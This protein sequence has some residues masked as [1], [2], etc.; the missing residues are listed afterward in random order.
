MK[1]QRWLWGVL[2]VLSSSAVISGIVA[3]VSA[4]IRMSVYFVAAW[5][6]YVLTYAWMKADART[7]GS[8]PPPGAIPLI[9]VLLPIAVSYYLLGTRQRWH[10]VLALCWLTGYVGIA[11]VVIILGEFIGRWL[12]T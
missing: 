8:T 12:V 11:F 1:A 2:V 9:P 4:D 10:K 5:P 6:V 3:H 7:L